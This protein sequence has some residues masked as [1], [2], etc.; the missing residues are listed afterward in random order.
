MTRLEDRQTLA[1][2]ITAAHGA[3]AR[4]APACT[5]AGIDL[6]TLQRWRAEDGSVRAD[7][8]PDAL[9]PTSPQALS[10]AERARIVAVANEP[11]GGTFSRSPWPKP[12]ESAMAMRLVV[13]LSMYLKLAGCVLKE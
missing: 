10:E 9:R 13:A 11:R 7:R 2:D 8:R 4:L 12:M 1:A 6:R 3:G 5:L